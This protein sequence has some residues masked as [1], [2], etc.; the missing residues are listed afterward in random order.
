LPPENTGNECQD[1]AVRG[2]GKEALGPLGQYRP[3]EPTDASN[4]ML[5]FR[6]V[7]LSE[8]SPVPSKRTVGEVAA[9]S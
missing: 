6:D 3:R 7:N 8:R 5:L 2:T 1:D 4:K 9:R